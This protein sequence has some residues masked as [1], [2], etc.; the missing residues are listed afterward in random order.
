MK[1]NA[2]LSTL[3]LATACH[4]AI[5]A[6]ITVPVYRTSEHGHGVSLGTV[7]FTDSQYGMLIKPHLEQLSPGIH[8]FHIHV[9]PDCSNMGLAAGGHLDPQHT[10]HHLGPYNPHGHLGDL[11][12]L[13]VDQK[14]L[15]TLP[16]LAPRLTVAKIKGH[17]LMI[18]AGSDNYSDHPALGGGGSR[19]ACGVIS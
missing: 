8:G 19:I 3:L 11:P 17:S 14:G 6:T 1:L 2:L 9:K 15:A 4:S 7:T 12:A 13:T 16:T 5:A 10:D 18:H